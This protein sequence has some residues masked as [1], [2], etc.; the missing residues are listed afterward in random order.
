MKNKIDFWFGGLLYLCWVFFSL[1]MLL[2]SVD[3]F[4]FFSWRLPWQNP[5][6]ILL[7][8]LQNMII[9]PCINSLYCLVFCCIKLSSFPMDASFLFV[10]TALQLCDL[11]QCRLTIGRL[12]C[13]VT[14]YTQ[15][16]SGPRFPEWL[17][18]KVCQNIY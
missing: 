4:Y 11:M 9:N 6:K 13:T 7:L 16:W 2:A 3:V 14:S 8:S 18:S 10:N 15:T 5:C 1:P 17:L 12:K